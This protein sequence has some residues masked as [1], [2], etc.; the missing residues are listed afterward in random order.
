[1]MILF[2][3]EIH[4]KVTKTKFVSKQGIFNYCECDD[5]LIKI[6]CT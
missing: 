3:F 1:M 4:R 5:L 2:G 6:I